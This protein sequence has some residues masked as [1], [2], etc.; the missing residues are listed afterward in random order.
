MTREYS[1]KIYIDSMTY[2][3][4][5]LL[6]ISLNIYYMNLDENKIFKIYSVKMRE[7]FKSVHKAEKI[8]F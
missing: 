6:D 4:W 3:L 5:L 1:I 2:L 7:I 8:K